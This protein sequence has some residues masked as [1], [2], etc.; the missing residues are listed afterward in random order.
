[1]A[2]MIIEEEAVQIPGWLRALSITVGIIAI[3]DAIIVLVY[4]AIG[5]ATLIMLMAI[6]LLLIGIERII[7]GLSGRM[8]R[9]VVH[10]KGVPT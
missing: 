7:L 6:G 1:M 5:L 3:V 9:P 10:R 8:Y 4:P 2:E